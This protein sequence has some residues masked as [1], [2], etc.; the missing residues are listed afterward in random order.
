M[1]SLGKCINQCGRNLV[2]LILFLVD[3]ASKQ[4]QAGELVD[5]SG[6]AVDE[7]AKQKAM[8]IHLSAAFGLVIPFGSLIMPLVL[9]LIWKDRHAY[10][11]TMGREAVNF[12]LSMLIYYVSSAVL[13]IVQYSCTVLND[14]ACN[15][16]IMCVWL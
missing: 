12:H 10:I 16:V 2:G 11:D 4:S 5:S 6:Q 14:V 8:L 3:A 15:I 9:W 1:T 7:D 13:V